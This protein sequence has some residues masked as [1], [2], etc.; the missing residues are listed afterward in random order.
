MNTRKIVTVD[1]FKPIAESI[2]AYDESSPSCLVFNKV[3]YGG[4]NLKQ[5]IRKPG[6]FAG[7]KE[8][9]NRSGEPLAWRVHY[10]GFRYNAHR[11]VWIIHS[12]QIDDS[13]VIDHLDGNP[14]NNRIE[15]LQIKTVRENNQN[16]KLSSKNKSGVCGV[17][18]EHVE[19]LP[20]AWTATWNSAEGKTCRKRFYLK[21]EDS[22]IVFAQA[23]AYRQSKIQELI[24]LNMAYTDR[25]GR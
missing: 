15:N 5:Q 22:S 17:F 16:V 21:G 8:Y 24:S 6:D 4:R 7:S 13:K 1:Y 23:V 10:N 14:F 18:L 25:H 20:V 2:F 12:G 11:L 19:G 3:I 9:N